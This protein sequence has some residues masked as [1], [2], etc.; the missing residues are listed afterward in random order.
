[1]INRHKLRG[2]ERLAGLGQRQGLTGHPPGALHPQIGGGQNSGDARGG[3]RVIAE[4]GAVPHHQLRG[5]GPCQLLNQVVQ[6][7]GPVRRQAAGALPIHLKPGVV[8]L[9][10]AGI[11][12]GADLAGEPSQVPGHGL[13]GGAAGAGALGGPGQ[14]FGGGNP[15]AQPGKGAG[16][17]IHAEGV[18]IC[19]GVAGSLQCL[20]AEGHYC[21]G[22]CSAKTSDLP[23]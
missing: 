19:G 22:M 14:P 17:Y 23:G 3:Q 18:H 8:D 5:L 4:L 15:D 11:H 21:L 13:Q 12:G 7:D 16:T 1:M 6:R 10:P 20:F 9:M 2:G